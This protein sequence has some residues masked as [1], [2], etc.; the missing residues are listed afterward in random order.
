MRQLTNIVFLIIIANILTN[1]AIADVKGGIEYKPLIDYSVMNKT[2]LETKAD[3]Y[4]QKIIN[5]G[6]NKLNNEI[7]QGLNLYTMLSGKYPDN[8]LY[9][10]RLGKLYDIIGKDKYAKG[11]YMHA[12]S[13]DKS[14]PEP[15][16]Y[17]G[18]FY[19]ARERYRKAFKMY[20]KSF[21]LG[22][23]KNEATAKRIDTLN[24]ILGNN[25]Q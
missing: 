12:I 22:Y 1:P 7:T 4:Y 15:Y 23:S 19:F 17:L 2:E 11:C 25:Q 20:L 3:F 6:Q 13:I 9:L 16:F 8:A 18:E 10:T 5:S 21:E 24:K 14:N